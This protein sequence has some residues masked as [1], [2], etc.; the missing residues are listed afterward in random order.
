MV[1]VINMKNEQKATSQKNFRF[2]ILPSF[3][4]LLLRALADFPLKCICH[5]IQ[6]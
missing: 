1:S 2:Y 5:F 4:V 3:L 6:T